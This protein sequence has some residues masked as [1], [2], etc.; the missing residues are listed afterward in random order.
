MSSNTRWCELQPAAVLRIAGPDAEP[1]LQGQFSQDV[2][3][4]SAQHAV[5]GL[6][7]DRRGRVEGDSLL[8]RQGEGWA[9]FSA[10]TPAATLVARLEQYIIA[11][12]VAV[13]DQTAAVAGWVVWSTSGEHPSIPGLPQLEPG[14]VAAAVLAGG[15]TAV[16]VRGR[17]PRGGLDV[18]APVAAADAVRAALGE[19]LG[20]P[21]AAAE[22][23]A[24]RIAEGI[25][26]VPEDCG[27]GELAQEA[28]L[29]AAAVAHDKGCYLGQEAVARVRAGGRLRRTLRRAA[30][31][32][33]APVRGMVLH[34]G[35]AR[36]GD[37][38]SVAA[39]G[40]GWVALAYVNTAC[41]AASLA[42]EPGGT[43]WIPL[44]P[45]PTR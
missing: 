1:F 21:A 36:V 20:A 22:L 3:R 40:T 32:G 14:G 9:L 5:Y 23:E 44:L 19:A 26:A 45:E 34:D 41:T 28:G 24:E 11:D 13:E 25:A 15:V 37:V 18:F 29:E 4:A 7:L 43:P 30:G 42:T 10:G 33:A 12:D 17:R 31:A 8:W 38:R 16:V 35:G 27:P 6:W 39:R 2:R